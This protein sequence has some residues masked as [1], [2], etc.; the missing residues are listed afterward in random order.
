[1]D[2]PRLALL[3]RLTELTESQLTSARNLNGAA[4]FDLNERRADVLF[5][6]RVALQEPVSTDPTVRQAISDEALRL[7]RLERR[8]SHVA[9]LVLDTLER[10]T[11]TPHRPP[12]TY[13]S[14]G[15][16]TA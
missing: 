11:P 6:L 5:S 14:T 8:L 15:R 1:M 2:D 12:T 7:R 10:L 13:G 4:M 16:L 9:T 3:R